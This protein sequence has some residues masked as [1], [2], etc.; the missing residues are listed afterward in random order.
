MNK[1]CKYKIEERRI[2]RRKQGKITRSLTL[3][4]TIATC[5]GNKTKRKKWDCIKQRFCITNEKLIKMT[6]SM[7]Q[8]IA[9]K[10]CKLQD[11]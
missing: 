4:L 11:F 5:T 9:Y 8:K 7:D 2:L 10:P 6:Q 3:V 1:I